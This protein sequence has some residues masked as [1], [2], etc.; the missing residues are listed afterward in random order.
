MTAREYRPDIDGLRAVAVLCVLFYHLDIA[1]FRGGF[2]GVD[3]F[4][5]ISGYL[6]TGLIKSEYQS[7]GKFNFIRFYVRRFKRIFPALFVTGLLSLVAAFFLFTPALFSE[8]CGSFVAALVSVSN[9]YF[10]SLV[11][12]FNTSAH[13][14]PLL[15]TWSL[16]V[17]EQYYLIAPA[18]GLIA[19]RAGPILAPL[20]IAAAGV[21]SLALNIGLPHMRTQYDVPSTIFYLMPFR[22]FEFVIG[23]LLCWLPQRDRPHRADELF[24]PLGLCMIGVAAVFYSDKLL[25]PSYYALL[26]C[27][28][29]ALAIYSGR[30]NVSGGLLRNP[31][32]VGTGLISYSL[33]LVHWPII[34][35]YRYTTNDT[36]TFAAKI[37]ISTAS[38]AVAYL[39]F[40]FIE[41]PFR[42]SSAPFN[43]G[44]RHSA[45]IVVGLAVF[46][47]AAGWSFGGWTAGYPEN[48]VRQLNAEQAA[49][50][51]TFTHHLMR[52]LDRDFP[53]SQSPRILIVGDS[54]SGDFLNLMDRAGYLDKSR[55]RLF[56]MNSPCPPFVT[57][58]RNVLE[59]EIHP[60]PSDC[61]KKIELL[62][63]VLRQSKPARIIFALLWQDWQIDEVEKAVLD[64]QIRG[65]DV[66]IIGLKTISVSGQQFLATNARREDFRS[67]RV[68]PKITA[69]K[70]NASLA[71]IAQKTNAAFY[72]PL[73]LICPGNVC[74]ISND[75][76][77]VFYFD[78]SHLTEDGVAHFAPIF[79]REWGAKIFGSLT[80]EKTGEARH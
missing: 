56:T 8:F 13:M 48:V 59:R 1:A 30:A 49:R 39:M 77:D 16:G 61:E 50:T 68:P 53:D 24:L 65:I 31:L 3:V 76:K 73:K 38:V 47:A 55:T 32:A 23:A 75:R 80:A 18:F 10:W 33:Y 58:G 22:I 71:A 52:E 26:P 29:A 69:L 5:V 36:L 20:L 2:N 45:A 17:E 15:H 11:S 25:F 74:D 7:T 4:L 66:S 51:D 63:T 46:V 40:R 44:F 54:M 70:I 14:K 60:S 37:A 6:I 27:G 12:Y 79:G 41:K 62:D 19:L 57:I 43:Y 34:V 35:F 72:D 78:D 42:Y 9:I 28:G 21:A 64:A 67:I